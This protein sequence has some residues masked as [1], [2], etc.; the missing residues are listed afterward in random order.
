MSERDQRGWFEWGYGAFGNGDPRDFSPD[1]E[2]CTEDEIARWKS[3]L[4]RVAAGE[5]VV[6]H[7]AGKRV[8]AEDGRFVMHILAPAYGIG[9]YKR[10]LENEDDE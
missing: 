5:I 10:R 8:Y 7:P 1:F 3:D 2:L 6:V 9:T 4:G